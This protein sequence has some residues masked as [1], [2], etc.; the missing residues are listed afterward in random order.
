M[1]KVLNNIIKLFYKNN[2]VSHKKAEELAEDC[3]IIFEEYINEY[4]MNIQELFQSDMSDGE[5]LDELWDM[6]NLE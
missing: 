3:V 2:V 1:D 6:F 5:I 4:R